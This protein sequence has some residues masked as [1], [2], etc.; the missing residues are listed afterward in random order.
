MT[1]DEIMQAAFSSIDLHWAIEDL[2]RYGAPSNERMTL[3]M[4]P[5][6]LSQGYTRYEWWEM[7][8]PKGT[9]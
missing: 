1:D 3:L 5:E 4:H 6:H 2:V 7:S 9:P 8:A